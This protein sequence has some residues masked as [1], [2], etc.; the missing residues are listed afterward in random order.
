MC[1]IVFGLSLAVAVAAA[2]SALGIRPPEFTANSEA[3]PT[4]V[5]VLPLDILQSQIAALLA[6]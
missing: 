6:R 1:N 2:G 4:T 5:R 3:V